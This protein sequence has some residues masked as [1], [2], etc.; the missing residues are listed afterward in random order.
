MVAAAPFKSSGIPRL[1]ARVFPVPSGNTPMATVVPARCAA[2]AESVPSPPPIIT[3]AARAATSFLSS[4]SVSSLSVSAWASPNGIPAPR[5]SSN[6]VSKLSRPR[7]EWVLMSTVIGRGKCGTVVGAVSILMVVE[8]T[9]SCYANTVREM[10]GPAKAQRTAKHKR[11]V[12]NE[13][14][15]VDCPSILVFF[16]HV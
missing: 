11:E 10:S 2:Q 5:S 7:R 13:K 14:R 1:R 3:V 8:F 15:T 6:A 9:A 12:R 4:R 16:N